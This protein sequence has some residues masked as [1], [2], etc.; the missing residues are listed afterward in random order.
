MD[1]EL[2]DYLQIIAD[3]EKSVYSQNKAINEVQREID[4]LAI[5]NK[6]PYPAKRQEMPNG[7]AEGIKGFLALGLIIGGV[8]GVLKGNFLMCIVIGIFAS[9]LLYGVI[10]I[11]SD[12]IRESSNNKEFAKQIETY[13]AIVNADNCRVQKEYNQQQRL[14]QIKHMMEQ[15]RDK[16]ASLLKSY[17]DTGIIYHKYRNFVAVC[18]IY[19]Y[20][21]SGSCDTLKEA[22]NKYD[23]ELLF[24]RIIDKMDEIIHNLDSIKDNQFMLYDAIQDGNRLSKQLVSASIRQSELLQHSI[25]YQALN[26]NYNAQLLNEARYQNQ[27]TL[28]DMWQRNREN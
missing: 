28:Y 15:K 22:Y 23:N 14:F 11:V 6:Y 21:L 16:S 24:K 5:P 10:C 13:N 1:K 9:A 18:S 26:A 7:S 3:M 25:D 19:E 8:V 12:A 20:F 2:R 4:K 27:L 17:Y